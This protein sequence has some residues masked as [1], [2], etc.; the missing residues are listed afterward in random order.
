MVPAGALLTL[1]AGRRVIPSSVRREPMSS[2]SDRESD[3][4]R[5]SRALV[6]A[7][8]LLILCEAESR[9]LASSGTGV[10]TPPR[11]IEAAFLE[12]KRHFWEPGPAGASMTQ[13]LQ[14]EPL[15]I[16][17]LMVLPGASMTHSRF[18]PT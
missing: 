11:V 18:V 12:R 8:P 7:F 2:T 6:A 15:C 16:E 13:V 10:P 17:I 4:G 14:A 3:V 1:I 9:A 5:P